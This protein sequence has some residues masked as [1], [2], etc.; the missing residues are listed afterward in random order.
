[1]ETLDLYKH[2]RQLVWSP[3]VHNDIDYHFMVAGYSSGKTTGGASTLMQ[4]AH[5]YWRYPVKIGIFGP[6]L[7]FLRKTLV[8][9]FVRFLL[10]SKS[11][12][13]N[14]RQQNVIQIGAM[15][16]VLIGTENPDDIYGHN[17]SAAISDEMDELPQDKC[18]RAFTAINERTRV[19]F[20]DGHRPFQTHTTTAQGYKG[21]YRIIED[22][23]DKK[24]SYV[25]IRGRTADNLA[26][27]PEYIARL[28]A[29]YDEN[30]RL[31]FLEGYFVNLLTGRVYPGYDEATCMVEPFE[32]APS[33]IIEVG[34]DLNAGFSKGV[35]VVKRG[36]RL[37]VVK[38]WSFKDI[39]DAPR[40][41]RQDFPMNRI[42]WYPDN[43]GKEIL[44][45]YR[46]EIDSHDIE[47]MMSG[48][49][50]SILD[51]IFVLNKLF[52]TARCALFGTCKDLAIALKT[53]QFND[54]GV[55]EKG[56]GETDASHICDAL[57]YVIFRLVTSDKDYYDLYE[58]TRTYRQEQK[59]P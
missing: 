14:D 1:V 49:N 46:S 23:K 45:G 22:L 43:S 16:Y 56:Q 38:T 6:S 2:Q 51:R 31:A 26:N 24:Q 47:N 50:P 53:R 54:N 58:M 48:A 21:M 30:E 27:P 57:E 12:Y 4:L 39:G 37:H 28:A 52:K 11:K 18:L 7:T 15:Q 59:K 55:A 29:L 25:H 8:G 13:R 35:A 33:D 17:L 40:I 10:Q 3:W 42:R 9:D 32:V 41:M 20:P 34:Q 5:R 19:P 44:R 36:R